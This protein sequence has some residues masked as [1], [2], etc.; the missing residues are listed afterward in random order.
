MSGILQLGEEQ[1]LRSSFVVVSFSIA[2]KRCS[3]NFFR[4]RISLPLGVPD[5]IPLSS[6]FTAFCEG[7]FVDE[8]ILLHTA[9]QLPDVSCGETSVLTDVDIGAA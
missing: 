7:I 9:A 6:H 8:S 2:R 4:A 1:K 5:G 3:K